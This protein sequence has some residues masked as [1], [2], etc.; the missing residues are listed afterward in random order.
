MI[1]VLRDDGT[2]DPV[3]DPRLPADEVVKLYRA[4]VTTR[5]L[6]ER[7]VTL[8]RQGRI[9]FHVGSLGEEAAIIG[10]A[11]AMRPQDWLFPCYREVGA[12]LWRGLALQTFIDNVFGNRN[13]VV[14]GHQ[15]PD[16]CTCRSGNFASVSSPVGSQIP[17]AVGVAWAARLRREDAAALVY[18]GDGA[19]STGD[20]HTSMNFAGVFKLPVVFLC[21]NNGWA[22]STPA[23]RQC[24]TRTFAEKGIAY[25][26]PGVQVDGNDVLAMVAVTRTAVARASSGSGPTLIEA[27]TYRMGAHT[28]SDDPSRYRTEAQLRPWVDRDPIERLRRHLVAA[29][30]WDQDREEALRQELDRHLHAAVELAERA[31]LPPLESMLEDVYQRPS[32][33]LKE[34]CATLLSGPRAPTHG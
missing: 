26:V 22:I 32:W 21:R 15:M 29:G 13:D 2:V 17:H 7:L 8:Q 23:E 18:F 9:G 6:D 20:F 1:R 11:Y 4:M 19:T 5:F 33:H 28:S 30:E 16:H 34:Q 3:D 12:A 24:M 10:A 27:V 14:K 25:G 31:P